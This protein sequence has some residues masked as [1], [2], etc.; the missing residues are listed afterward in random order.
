M[1][2]GK[3]LDGLNFKSGDILKAADLQSIVDEVR[4][5]SYDIRGGN[6][7]QVRRGPRGA[8]QISADTGG[9]FLIKLTDNG[10][11]DTP[12][13]HEWKRV[14]SDTLD[15]SEEGTVAN[16]D[17]AY[18]LSGLACPMGDEILLAWRDD[19]GLLVFL[20]TSQEGITSEAFSAGSL[21]SMTNG[22]V[23]L[24]TPQSGTIASSGLTVTAYNR[25]NTAIASSTG[26]SLR[27]WC[28]KWLIQTGEC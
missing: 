4:N 21:G 8:I 28:G 23:L 26:V 14:Y 20:A 1:M 7:L 16:G 3:G 24:Y 6:G 22:D 9:A 27:P 10:T 19:Y 11:T 18:E 25:W 2:A 13:Q 15:G 5:P 17:T 12:P